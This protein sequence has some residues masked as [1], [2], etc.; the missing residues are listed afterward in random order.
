MRY[1]TQYRLEKARVLLRSGNMKVQDVARA[2][3]Y[4][5]ASYFC[6]LFRNEYGKTPNQFREQEAGE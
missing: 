4:E 5:N 6:M 1:I 2:V 3:G